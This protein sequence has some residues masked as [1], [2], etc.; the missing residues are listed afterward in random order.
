MKAAWSRLRPG[1]GA[2]RGN[3]SGLALIEFALVFPFLLALYLG[4]YQLM[5]G[6]S[7]ARKLTRATRTIADL[8][9]QNSAVSGADLDGIL[10]ASTQVMYPYSPTRGTFRVTSIAIDHTG[11]GKVSWSKSRNGQPLVKDASFVLPPQ[12]ST[13]IDTTVVLS[14]TTYLYDTAAFSVGVGSIPLKN[15]IYMLPRA[16][17]SIT[18]K[19]NACQGSS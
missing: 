12:F 2:L 10:A 5:D 1:L 17:A 9:S 3:K 18:C 15:Q 16:S 14:E 11:H 7:A 4:G 19:D 8:T 6:M 13:L